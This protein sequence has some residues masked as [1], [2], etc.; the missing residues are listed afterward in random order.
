MTKEEIKYPSYRSFLNERQY[1]NNSIMGLLVGS[2]LAS[3]VLGVTRGSERT[4]PEIF[5]NVDKIERF[6]LKP[7]FAQKV[8]EDAEHHLGAMA[9]PHLLGLHED[10]GKN[11]LQILQES[12]LISSSEANGAKA[13]N[14]HIKFS[15]ATSENL[16]ESCVGIYEILRKMRN[17]I[18]HAGGLANAS[19]EE[20]LNSLSIE[21]KTLWENVTKE[22][23]PSFRTGEKIQ[24]SYP[25]TIAALAVLKRLS[26]QMNHILGRVVGK[27]VWMKIMIEDF[28]NTSQIHQNRARTVNSVHRF[29]SFNYAPLKFSKEEIEG[30]LFQEGIIK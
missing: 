12:G 17:C 25:E 20:D 30:F 5:P 10:Y 19:L 23:I 29:S 8:L 1:T 16:D 13:W 4:L 21:T 15:A 7:E 11:C 26:R 24:F 9:V 18:I 2:K 3:H 22:K 28:L 27:E 6:N 14:I